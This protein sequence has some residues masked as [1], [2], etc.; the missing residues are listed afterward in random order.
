MS[1]SE[2]K[3]INGQVSK[4]ENMCLVLQDVTFDFFHGTFNKKKHHDAHVLFHEDTCMDNG[5]VYYDYEVWSPEPCRICMCDMG[6]AVCEEVVCEELRDCL[7]SEVPEGECCPVCS[8]EA[9]PPPPLPP[10][11]TTATTSSKNYE[12]GNNKCFPFMCGRVSSNVYVLL[13]TNKHVTIILSH[14]VSSAF[15][16][17]KKHSFGLIFYPCLHFNNFNRLQKSNSNCLMSPEG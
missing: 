9:P 2:L 4:T 8:T 12:S 14:S 17:C 15:F 11:P 10:P 1:I 5:E 7:T 16:I 3:Y 6:T 13:Q